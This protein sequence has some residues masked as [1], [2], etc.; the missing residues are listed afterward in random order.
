[1][2]HDKNELGSAYA[3]RQAAAAVIEQLRITYMLYV[4][5]REREREKE[6]KIVCTR[7]RACAF[8]LLLSLYVRDV[9]QP[10]QCPPWARQDGL[11]SPHATATTDY[12]GFA[13]VAATSANS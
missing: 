6:E 12:L 8:A 7:L 10:S 13:A 4:L 2:C 5:E 11:G 1:M 9:G 3:G